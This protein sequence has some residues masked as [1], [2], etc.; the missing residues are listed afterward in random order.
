MG[1]KSSRIWTAHPS[2]AG[3]P[4]YVVWILGNR[5]NFFRRVAI[6]AERLILLIRPP[7]PII[8]FFSSATVQKL[9]PTL[10]Y[11]GAD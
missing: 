10:E 7:A 8:V 5:G 4:R 6:G 9:P 3:A 2:C 1:L 11:I